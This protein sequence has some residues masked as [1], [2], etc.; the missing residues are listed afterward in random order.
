[1]TGIT[2]KARAQMTFEQRH[3]QNRQLESCLLY[4]HHILN[5]ISTLPIR[6]SRAT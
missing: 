5:V 3:T 6:L 1:M 4:D 2:L